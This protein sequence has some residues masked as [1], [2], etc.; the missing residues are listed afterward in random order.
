MVRGYYPK[1]NSN[2]SGCGDGEKKE[3]EADDDA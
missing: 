3:S 2:M 1:P